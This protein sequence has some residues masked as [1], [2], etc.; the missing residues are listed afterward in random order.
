LQFAEKNRAGRVTKPVSF[1]RFAAFESNAASARIARNWHSRLGYG[2]AIWP[3][4]NRCSFY[5]SDRQ[6]RECVGGVIH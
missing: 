4:A 2:R 6:W 3:S 1:I 5:F